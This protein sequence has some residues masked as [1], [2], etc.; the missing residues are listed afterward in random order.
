MKTSKKLLSQWCAY[1]AL[2]V[3]LISSPLLT[4]AFQATGSIEAV[5]DASATA[6]NTP[7]SIDVLANDIGTNLSIVTI[8][9]F[10]NFGVA[11]IVGD[12]IIYT[13]NFGFEGT[14][15]FNYSISDDSGNISEG[16]ITVVVGGSGSG[17][18]DINL[19]P[20][21]ITNT[22]CTD[23][24][25]PV[26]ICESY[27]DPNGD[28]VSIDEESTSTLFDCS[29]TFLNDTCLRYTPLPGFEGTD[30]VFI[31]VCDNQ[32]P[33]LCSTSPIVVHVGC[34]TPT[35]NNDAVTIT[36]TN[37]ITNGS[38]MPNMGATNTL[39]VLNNDTDLCDEEL[40]V[41][42]LVVA[43]ANGSAAVS[44]GNLLYTPTDGFEGTDQLSYIMCNDCGLC[45]E[46]TVTIEVGLT[47]A[48][49]TDQTLCI[50]PFVGVDICPE[51]CDIPADEIATFTFS[52]N[53]GTIIPLDNHCVNYT[54]ASVF[55][56]TNELTF[57]A[58]N[59]TGLC[60]T[61]IYTVNINAE[62]GDTPPVAEDDIATVVP[63]QSIV[64]F[65]L[66]N[67]FDLDGDAL[68]LSLISEFSCGTATTTADQLI[69]TA[70][71]GDCTVDMI[72]YVVCD[73]TGLCDTA[74]ITIF[75]EE[76]IDECVFDTLYCSPNFTFP[77]EIC[78]PSC[79]FSIEDAAITEVSTVFDCSIVVNNDTCLTY[80]PLPGFPTGL[81]S[82]NITY[83]NSA[84]VCGTLL[85][86]VFVG[87]PI[88]TAEDDTFILNETEEPS[89]AILDV[90]ENDTD[91]C[92]NPL[93]VSILEA[94]TNGTASSNADGTT[95]I[96]TPNDGFAGTEI[97][98]Y[99]SCNEC[100]TGDSECDT[101]TI[102]VNII[103]DEEP[104]DTTDLELNADFVQTP[105]N[106]PISVDV[107]N[108]D[109]GDG[110]LLTTIT[111]NPA[112]GTATL[113]GSE[114][115]YT[116]NDGFVGTDYLFYEACDT[117]GVCDITIL[118][119]EVLP[120]DAENLPPIATND[121]AFTSL[122]TPVSIDVLNN[123]AD[124]EN[125]TLTITEVSPPT[126][127]TAEIDPMTQTVVYT[128]NLGFEGIDFF[129]YTIC[130]EQGAC[131]VAAVS[132]AVTED[133]GLG[134]SNTP[135]IGNIDVATV[136]NDTSVLINLLVN[137]TDAETPLNIFV[138][139]ITDPANGTVLNNSDGTV[140]YTPN[141]DFVGED[142]F[143]Y[144]VCDDGIP[145]L[146]DLTY[147]VITVTE[148]EPADTVENIV[149][150][151]PDITQ[152][153]FNTPIDIAVTANDIGE[154]IVV[155]NI[156]LNPS[157][158]TVIIS[159]D[160]TILYEPNSGTVG[161]DYF[162]YEIC[163]ESGI[164]DTTLVSVEILAEDLPNQPP[165]ANNDFATTE[166]DTPIEIPV[167]ANDS[168][169]EGD[170]IILNGATNPENGSVSITIDETII[171]TPDSGFVG[172]DTFTY[173]IVDPDGASDT[174]IV[175][176]A[177]GEVP[178]SLVNQ[179]PVA[180]DD[181]ATTTQT[182]AV[183]IPIL[184]NDTNEE[185][186]QTLTVTEITDP[187][188]GT[189][190]DNEDGTVTYTP[191]PSFTGTDYFQYVVCDNGVPP[192]CDTAN[193]IVQV[194]LDSLPLPP[195]ALDDTVSTNINLLV[196]IEM[197]DNDIDPDGAI[198]DLTFEVLE[199]P[200]NGTVATN[201]S[202]FTYEPFP[203]FAGEDQF[204]YVICDPDGL[205]DTATVFITV[206]PAVMAQPDI[207]YTTESTEVIIPVLDNDLGV[208]IAVTDI[209]DDPE[210]GVI[211]NVDN[212]DG[213][214]TYLPNDGFVGT[215][216]FVYAIC[217]NV[218]NCDTTVVAVIVQAE[219]LENLPPTASNDIAT[220]PVDNPVVID[221][222]DNDTDPNN[223]LLTVTDIIS[224]PSNGTAVINP[225]NENITYTPGAGFDGCDTL[226]YVVCDPSELC[227]TAIVLISVGDTVCNVPPIAVS[228][229][230][231][232][233]I[234]SNVIISVLDND[235]DPDG[236]IISV[237]PASEPAN[238]SVMLMPLG[239]GLIY[240]PALDFVGTDYF[241]Y[242]ICDDGSPSL[243]DTAYVV[244][245][246]EP[247][248]IDA[249]PDI[250]FTS[251]NTSV[252]IPILDNDEGVG[253]SLTS[254]ITNPENG[255]V[256]VTFDEE[257]PV[258]YTPNEDFV[259][260]DYFTYEICDDFGNCDITLVTVVVLPDSIENIA[261]NAVNDQ[262]TTSVNTPVV[263]NVLGNDNDPLGGD[264]I[265]IE[266]LSI[267]LPA[268]G[269]VVLVGDSTIE[270][271]PN[272]DFA[273]IDS[274]TY[275]ICDNGTPVLCDTA[276]VVV[277]VGVDELNNNPPI[278]VED[279]TETP[280][281]TSVMIDVLDND[282]DPDID[283][284]IV[285]DFTEP[286]NG[287]VVDLGDELVYTP[288][289]DYTGQDFFTYIICDD[290]T[291]VLCDTAFVVINVAS[292]T[293]KVELTTEQAA[294]ID[295]CIA[296][297]F[298][299][300][301]IVDITILEN[302]DNGSIIGL[303]ETCIQYLPSSDFVGVDTLFIEMCLAEDAC[304]VV[305]MCIAVGDVLE[306]P[307]AVDDVAS[308]LINTPIVIDV[309]DNDF[310]PDG[311]PITAI[312]ITDPPIDG[313]T[314]SI[315]FDSLT[316]EYIPAL[317]FTGI[318]TFC[319]VIID[320]TGM[321]S[322]T[323]CVVVSV[324]EELPPA[325]TI[326]AIN[327]IDTTL[328]DQQIIIDVL[329]N[330]IF[331]EGSLT[332]I[333]VIDFPQNGSTLLNE[334]STITYFPDLGFVGIDTFSYEICGTL[335]EGDAL[336]DTA[337]VVVIVL[338]QDTC[339]VS[340][341]QGFSP[342]GDGINEEFLITNIE[343]FEANQPE[344]IVF[345]RWGDVVYRINNYT[346]EFAWTGRWQATNEDVDDGTYFY[347][348]DLKTGDESG[349][350]NGFIEL[351]R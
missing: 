173:I 48:C 45:S 200:T 11:E 332:S 220:T 94:P 315:D 334:D 116:P 342:N 29:L 316:V 311:H 8:S 66:D 73:P 123:D 122:D 88:P 60:D 158:G 287:T 194:L 317:D 93:T 42:Q 137:D 68:G 16:M 32:V 344:L 23:L 214:V 142:Y 85:L 310:D 21:I 43:P 271:I 289:Q 225:D 59:T 111:M 337:E 247:S 184:A 139:D 208:F 103:E 196:Q 175:Q 154:D 96:Y 129:T 343:C 95:I 318:D 15:V 168:D 207:A 295:T 347:C 202:S 282:S 294:P 292:D 323:A 346:N 160:S 140:I 135:P 215:D 212:V 143:E 221:V 233:S 31:V 37:V 40:S 14:E 326:I 304:L 74:S 300:F 106:T 325:D 50:P 348:L 244:I 107:L 136:P 151:Q 132:V 303:G 176:V 102:I 232:T 72:D 6:V 205:C 262:G 4:F 26:I 108:N 258:T 149:D 161:I 267:T 99:L 77:A 127:G 133:G 163:N 320:S 86:N 169:P 288:N 306:P 24:F 199:P 162:I 104:S 260:T 219:P 243:C 167:V 12:A 185:E 345:N 81:D 338:P 157:F 309:L 223:D 172:T 80:T 270:Y 100:V 335:P 64:L 148:G 340:L 293:L 279:T 67:D 35:A 198:E 351:K 71:T 112:N 188:N 105:F 97:F 203:D 33:S 297:L 174:A 87:C 1:I 245:T 79:A 84:G 329:E 63:G 117:Y 178:D 130:D 307:V 216:Y 236:N 49:N 30:T 181:E 9:V 69:Y 19:P 272:T 25:T 195:I 177:V 124:P 190:I 82:L 285:T 115:I 128:P 144:I 147:V 305:Q 51:F 302:S 298:P 171:Y 218:G 230:I 227:D 286:A 276:T 249:E 58:C 341:A 182:Q 53:L 253:I 22:Y 206:V 290:G 109:I 211:T 333:T 20:N 186:E 313:A 224:G 41:T 61:T 280:I 350:I 18:G 92:G 238:G 113:T 242:I 138:A 291:P 155:T 78:L 156:I 339:T 275:A 56:G 47:N 125:G 261:P 164:C 277:V 248:I 28:P 331:E 204:T 241:T 134:D 257:A 165:V 98:T 240:T 268:N 183:D 76:V 324:G 170:L 114:I 179:P 75:Y 36:S 180:V 209:L 250:A 327:D 193:V 191:A 38:V 5:D 273:G 283:N 228:D 231:T 265:T 159:S 55:T 90:L 255:T 217:D 120:E 54:M 254:I 152:T 65:P 89:A 213:L 222:L 226:T 119:I 166:A 141:L 229:T 46:A 251:Q 239:D 308:T 197:L 62:C 153:P 17:G 3:C 256:E 266:P 145:N 321:T 39:N 13:P 274:F 263:I 210:N 121:I 27:T 131:D 322:D 246:I 2:L 349:L 237:T 7:V 301:D 296:D 189:V 110:V 192:F 91:I 328:V 264:E 83:C 10:P 187:I 235:T 201:T 52:A 312:I 281:N 314:T 101:A 330:D 57:V 44:E 284:I 146:C 252:P 269:A 319:Y 299:S 278:A 259:G 118:G 70:T 34:M 336:C 234:N 150:A 126:N